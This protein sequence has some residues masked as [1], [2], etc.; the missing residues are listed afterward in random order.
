M[1]L[2][3]TSFHLIGLLITGSNTISIRR[4]QPWLEVAVKVSHEPEGAVRAVLHLHS[5]GSMREKR[6][7]VGLSCQR[8]HVGPSRGVLFIDP[9]EAFGD[10]S[11]PS[12]S[13]ALRLLDELISGKYGPPPTAP[14]WV[15]D[16]GC[17]S[18]V[19]G[20]AA[21]A[22]GGFKVLGVDLDPHAIDAAQGNLRLNPEPGSKISLV[23]GEL[24]CARGPFCLVLAN[25]VPS[26]HVRAH[27]TLGRAVASGGWLILSGFF[28]TQKDLIS[29]PYVRNGATEKG[30]SLD[31]AWAGILLH[32]PER[33]RPLYR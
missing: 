25:L 7:T 29:L 5:C 17:G 18:G 26:V 1:C 16:A 2:Q 4:D 21:A 30:Y 27:K 15:L 32:K 23:L 19:L 10:G 3:D 20:L 12:T 28:Q 14:G 11:H 31:Q 9:R 8:V 6:V 22:L 33:N 13:L 24:L